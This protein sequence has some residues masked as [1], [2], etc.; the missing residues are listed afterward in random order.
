[1]FLTNVDVAQCDG[2]GVIVLGALQFN[3]TIDDR[4]STF[5]PKCSL[6]RAGAAVEATP[7]E[8]TNLAEA[9]E[10]EA[11]PALEEQAKFR[12]EQIEAQ[13][14]LYALG[15]TKRI[16]AIKKKAEKKRKLTRLEQDLL[17][18]DE[19]LRELNALDEFFVLQAT[20]IVS[21]RLGT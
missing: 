21:Q 17:D 12:A 20:E 6:A 10:K 2:C 9:I 18:R 3:W 5:C 1:M 19:K 13:T 7:E 4:D 15:W 11:A 16:E 14:K 8:M